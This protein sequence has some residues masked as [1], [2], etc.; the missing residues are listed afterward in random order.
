MKELKEKFYNWLGM[1]LYNGS[2]MF[3]NTIYGIYYQCVQVP[4]QNKIHELMEEVIKLRSEVNK[5]K[6]NELV[7][8]KD[9]QLPVEQTAEVKRK[10][11]KYTKHKEVKE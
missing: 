11:R 9:E 7:Q 8:F 10:R 1:K 5:Y 2:D 6:F 3:K 4:N